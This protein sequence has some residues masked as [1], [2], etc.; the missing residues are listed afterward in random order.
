MFILINKLRRCI[1]LQGKILK[2]GRRTYLEIIKKPTN[3]TAILTLG[4][5]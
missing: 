5:C 4:L 1:V 3:D 2:E